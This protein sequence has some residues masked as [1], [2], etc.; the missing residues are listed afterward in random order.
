[1][2]YIN[3]YIFIFDFIFKITLLNKFKITFVKFCKRYCYFSFYIIN[4]FG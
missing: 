1:M 4:T 3:F 2:F